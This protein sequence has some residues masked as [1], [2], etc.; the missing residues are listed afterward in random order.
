MLYVNN[1]GP[2]QTAQILI[3]ALSVYQYILQHMY[4]IF[5]NTGNIGPDPPALECS[6]LVQ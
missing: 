4:P 1:D 2:D 3:R 6:R 5:I